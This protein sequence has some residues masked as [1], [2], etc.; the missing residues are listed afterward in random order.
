MRYYQLQRQ[1]D[2]RSSARTTVRLL[3]SLLRLSEAHAKLMFRDTVTLVDAVVAVHC[4]SLAAPQSASLLGNRS[5]FYSLTLHQADP[6]LSADSTRSASAKDDFSA[7]PAAQYAQV[8]QHVFRLLHYSAE[9]LAREVALAQQQ[10]PKDSGSIRRD[11]H[12]DDDDDDP[13][14]ETRGGGG[15]PVVDP[16]NGAAVESRASDTAG[17]ARHSRGD[18]A[19]FA[20]EACD[21]NWS[22]AVPVPSPPLS[23]EADLSAGD[24]LC[25][26]DFLGSQAAPLGGGAPGALAGEE[27][28]VASKRKWSPDDGTALS[29]PPVAP[30]PDHGL[31]L[32]DEDEDDW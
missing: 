15:D 3:E 21:R 29:V 6:F 14:A 11:T 1:S 31:S 27:Q 16:A 17:S 19:C 12:D 8:E 26:D 9:A 22:A 7:D 10:Q 18:S 24:D 5:R 20:Q 2:E 30:L 32:R 28:R 13:K 4:V 25:V 23:N